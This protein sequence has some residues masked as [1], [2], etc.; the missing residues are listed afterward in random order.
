MAIQASA[1][2]HV[3]RS[4]EGFPA[5]PLT[6]S[7]WLLVTNFP[8]RPI[9]LWD[10][11]NTATTSSFSLQ[12]RGSGLN[13]AVQYNYTTGGAP[14][15]I[16]HLS[17]TLSVNTWYHF[18]IIGDTGPSQPWINFLGLTF[19]TPY[20]I[21]HDTSA[22]L[23]YTP[24]P[25]ALLNRLD[26]AIYWT[27][28]RIAAYKHWTA[29]L[30]EAELGAERQ[31]YLPVRTA[32]LWTCLPCLDVGALR[33]TS[34]ARHDWS[35][36]G[37]TTASGPPI[38][39]APTRLW[40][41]LPVGGAP[42]PTVRDLT[43]SLPG[44]STTPA[45]DW[46]TT[47]ALAALLTTDSTTPA[48][49][50]TL[51]LALTSSLAGASVTPAAVAALGPLRSLAGLITLWPGTVASIPTGWTRVT[52]LDG[53]YPKMAAAAAEPGA[54]GGALTHTHTSVAHA[55]TTAHTHTTPNTT[56]TTGSSARDAGATHPPFVHTHASNPAAPNP[57]T[58]LTAETPALASGSLE[59]PFFEVLFLVSDDT[60]DGFPA[61]SLAFWSDS[62]GLPAGWELCDGGGG[63]PDVRGRLLK[64]ATGG[65]N[66][67]SPGG[68][69]THSHT[70]A[71]H[72][73]S[74]PYAH[75]HP[76]VT[77][78]Q[79]TEAL[80]VAQVSGTQVL[81]ATA[82]HTHALTYGSSS[83]VITGAA[84]STSA[85]AHD[86]PFV[87]LACMQNTS[88]TDSWPAGALALWTGSLA[89]IPEDWHLC[90]GT[91]GTPD[92]RGLFIKGATT[93]G[94]IGTTGGSLTHSHTSTGHSHPVAAHTHTV[95]GGVGA[96]TLISVGAVNAPTDI[97]THTWPATS[98]NGFTSG[99][100]SPTVTDLSDTQPPFTTVVI[101]QWQ[102]PAAPVIVLT[103]SLEGTGATPASLLTT[104]RLVPATLSA[105]STTP[106]SAVTVL[107][108]LTS[109]LSGASLTTEAA[110][111]LPTLRALTA[112]ATGTSLTPGSAVLQARAMVAVV[113]GSS[114][115]LGSLATIDRTLHAAALA[116]STTPLAL[117]E[118]PSTRLLSAGLSA[119]SSTADVL[120][121]LAAVRVLSATLSG[122]SVTPARVATVSRALQAALSGPSTAP[123]VAIQQ[124]HLLGATLGASSTTPAVPTVLMQRRFSTT[125]AGASVT[126][127]ALAP[128]VRVLTASLS[129]ASLIP[130]AGVLVPGQVLLTAQA[131][132][133][134]TTPPAL[135]SM[136]RR[137][138]ALLAAASVT[139]PTVLRSTV[140]FQSALSGASVT[141]AVL[142]TLAR[143]LV[144][145]V[146]GLSTTP[147]GRVQQERPLQSAPQG[148]SLTP[149][150]QAHLVRALT[151]LLV[152]ST[153][154]PASAHTLARHLV[155][156]LTGSAATAPLVVTTV[157]PLAAS[158]P[159]VSLVP[160]AHV[161]PNS[162]EMACQASLVG[163]S[164]T[165][166]SRLA[167]LPPARIGSVG[168]RERVG[169]IPARPRLAVVS[170]E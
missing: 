61:Q 146:P 76:D 6:V 118:V 102:A 21:E 5:G 91:D 25:V 66:G 98:S 16:N 122:A 123:P 73:H 86:P 138:I 121:S 108:P 28:G 31:T 65:G 8:A 116:T 160:V 45:S 70:I 62:A 55:H 19:G 2:G 57:I 79:R 97:H 78:A 170:N 74:T 109:V 36:T 49:L 114:S 80:T 17:I 166:E 113:S 75:A 69:T 95:T 128:L 129:G 77:S 67:G 88:G 159:G 115:T 82:T 42:P 37:L 30:T 164:Q 147:P 163:S 26:P 157:R 35:A 131:L 111:A 132:A 50:V 68:S 119:S 60:T 38:A 139:P 3:L 48:S 143:A 130:A 7:F 105:V 140:I 44:T 168:A 101:L 39:W 162:G 135:V 92:L 89:S 53:I 156:L 83:P 103:A 149:P 23:A 47:R 153:A 90:D 33:D 13:D 152:G 165:S 54:T 117:L 158:V 22:D 63:R 112:A 142:S 32:N 81:V 144:A 154:T 11:A 10:L 169:T 52:A 20:R 133:L 27:E 40:P 96:S 106:S 29:R 84:D 15:L 100:A 167:I 151:G 136:Q 93:L 85:V 124:L 41:V 51:D 155:A 99:S 148:L 59:P 94:E 150:V 4:L 71:S 127:P 46:T 72:T 137:V 64:G 58:T 1:S 161:I 9:V 107:R 24:Q 34:T 43:A 120:A 134:S 12:L 141:P 18:G 56:G 110:H 14:A 104:E 126:L 145:L 125:L 87:L